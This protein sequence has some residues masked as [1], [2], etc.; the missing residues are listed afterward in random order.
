V[1]DLLKSYFVSGVSMTI[2]LDL[3]PR[4]DHLK[5]REKEVPSKNLSFKEVF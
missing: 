4:E 2:N 1:K 5:I 3:R